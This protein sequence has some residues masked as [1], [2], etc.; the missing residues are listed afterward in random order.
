[1]A[2]SFPHCRRSVS[3][4]PF[5]LKA[6]SLGSAPTLM[7]KSPSFCLL[8][9]TLILLLTLAFAL[10]AIPAATNP[11]RARILERSRHISSA[12]KREFRPAQEAGG[13][14][15]G[16]SGK[17]DFGADGRR[18]GYGR[19]GDGSARVRAWTAFVVWGV[20]F[21][22][23]GLLVAVGIFCLV[24]LSDLQHDYVNP[25]DSASSINRF[26]LPEMAVHATL[27]LLLLLFPP[28]LLG[29]LLLALNA[30]LL[31]LHARSILSGSYTVDVTEIFVQLPE[32][33]RLWQK[34][35]ILYCLV[36]IPV[37]YRWI[38]AA[39]HLLVI[40]SQPIAVRR[41]E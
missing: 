14:A 11:D 24:T 31:L 10:A 1:M 36:V 32:L 6:P 18:A 41:T 23:A 28:S 33:R 30:P 15:Q 9:R 5:A 25:H 38:L 34:K 26:L 20:A 8:L 7:L 2:V 29:L 16:G 19:R 4:I 27:S 12:G 39:T 17:F 37:V 21:V 22:A 40:T 35:L 3:R 13:E